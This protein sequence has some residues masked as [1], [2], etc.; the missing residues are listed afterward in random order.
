MVKSEICQIW[1]S[2]TRKKMDAPSCSTNTTSD[3]NKDQIFWPEAELAGVILHELL[4]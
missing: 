3:E 2:V 4:K 1:K